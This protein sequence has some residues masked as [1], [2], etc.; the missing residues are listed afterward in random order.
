MYL[1]RTS[2]TNLTGSIVDMSEVEVK[3]DA[4]MAPVFLFLASSLNV[5][6]VYIILKGVTQFS[7]IGSQ[8][9][10]IEPDLVTKEKLSKLT[11]RQEYGNVIVELYQINIK[12]FD[13]WSNANS[14][15]EI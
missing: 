5:E 3:K 12:D 14:E 2:T 6:L 4:E 9:L 7:Y 13:K 11:Y 15:S 8:Q 10:G 1:R